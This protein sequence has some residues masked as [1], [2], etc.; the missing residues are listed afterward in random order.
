M[1]T[2]RVVLIFYRH[3]YKCF[4]I[5]FFQRRRAIEKKI[6]ENFPIHKN[7]L[8]TVIQPLFLFRHL[9]TTLKWISLFFFLFFFGTTITYI[10]INFNTYTT[11]PVRFKI[12]TLKLFRAKGSDIFFVTQK[13]KTASI[14]IFVNDS[15]VLFTARVRRWILPPPVDYNTVYDLHLRK[16]SIML[17]L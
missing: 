5:T 1:W 10:R 6:G 14:T 4:E 16:S 3:I 7:V 15:R 8:R 12:I 9:D 17:L 13:K 2:S 11:V